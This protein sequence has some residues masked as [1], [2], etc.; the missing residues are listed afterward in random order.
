MLTKWIL[1][2][3][4]SDCASVL[5]WDSYYLLNENNLH[6]SEALTP[7]NLLFLC[8]IIVGE[9][10]VFCLQLATRDFENQEKTILTGDCCYINPLV[11]RTVRFLGMYPLTYFNIIIIVYKTTFKMTQDVISTLRRKD[12]NPWILFFLENSMYAIKLNG[13]VCV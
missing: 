1:K 11:R 4:L 13:L 9:T 3:P 12:G 8:K 7:F 10:A 6:T 2:G 5:H